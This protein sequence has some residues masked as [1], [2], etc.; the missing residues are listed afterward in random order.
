MLVPK[1]I[2]L[3]TWNESWVRSEKDKFTIVIV[4][5]WDPNRNSVGWAMIEGNEKIINGNYSIKNNVSLTYGK[6]PGNVFLG[7]REFSWP[8]LSLLNGSNQVSGNE[9]QEERQS[10]GVREL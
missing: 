6:P 10:H 2:W 3:R 1:R 8:K 4:E 7:L 9:Q 5:F